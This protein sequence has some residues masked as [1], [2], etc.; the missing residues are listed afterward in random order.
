MSA[1]EQ[2]ETGLPV[3]QEGEEQVEKSAT[4]VESTEKPKLNI[5]NWLNLG[6]YVLN[7]VFTFGIG[8]NGWFGNGTNGELSLKY[9]TIVTPA[10]DAFRIWILIF[11]LQAIFAVVQFLPRFRATPMLQKGVGYWYCCVSLFQVAWTFSFAYEVLWLSLF[12]MLLILVSLWGLLYS[13]YY[14][15]SDGSLWEF[16]LLRFPFA[17]HGGWITAASVVNTNV[18][19]VASSATPATELAIGIVSLAYLH[20]IS[21]WVLFGIKRNPNYTIAGVLAWAI[22][23]I[24]AELQTPTDSIQARFDETTIDGVALAAV[25]VAFIITGQIVVRFGMYILQRYNKK[26]ADAVKGSKHNGEEEEEAAPAET[27]DEKV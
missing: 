13:Q 5:K 7:I 12:F 26:Y 27:S 18:I 25:I 23:Y 2:V 8:T 19:V 15:E 9:Q 14:T 4:E 1:T 17:L 22:G 20:A 6:A 21:V 11:L 10:S 16:W 3:E 24:N